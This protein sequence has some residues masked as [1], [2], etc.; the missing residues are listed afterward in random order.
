MNRAQRRQAARQ[1]HKSGTPDT[2]LRAASAAPDAGG[3]AGVADARR[4]METATRLYRSGDAVNAANIYQRVLATEPDNAD[5]LH[6]LGLCAG[7]MGQFD[8]AME[9]VDRSIALHPK[10]AVYHNNRGNRL[11]RRDRPEEAEEAY[12]RAVAIDPRDRRAW[13]NLGITLAGRQH[14]AK[15]ARAFHRAIKADKTFAEAHNNLANVLHIEGRFDAAEKSYRRAIAADPGYFMACNN[16]ANTLSAVGRC[17]EAIAACRRAVEIDPAYAVGYNTLASLLQGNG[18]FA[19]S[20]AAFRKSI[21][22]DPGS[23]GTWNNFGNALK[24]VGGHAE[25]IVCFGKA[26]EI[27]P[28]HAMAHSNLLFCMGMDAN[29]TARE[30]FIQSRRWNEIH[31]LPR[32]PAARR[33]ENDRDPERRLRVGYV[34]PDFR[35]HAVSHFIAPLIDAHDRDAVAVIAYA[36]VA[37]P[38]ETTHRIRARMDEWCDTVGMT[39][40]GLAARIRADRIDILVDLAGHTASNRLLTF[41]QRPAPVQVAWLGYGG[42]TGLDAMEYRLTD[43][44]ADPQGDADRVHS[45]TLV[46][47]AGGFLCY[48][49]PADAPEPGALPADSGGFVTFASFNSLA[50]VTPQAVSAWAR[51]LDAVPDAHLIIKGNALSD[52]GTRRRYLA[53]FA[54]EG[55]D[56]GRI[57]LAAQL[58]SRQEYLALY[59]RADIVLDSFPYNGGTTTCEALWMGVPVVTLAGDRHVSRMSASILGRVGADDLVAHSEDEYVATA[60]RLAGDRS[61][62]RELR[63]GLRATMAASPLCDGPAF[64]RAVE[65]A[66]RD[67][68]RRWCAG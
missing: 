25:A 5:A 14:Y 53:H 51:V 49:P 43:A 39:D 63:G 40:A 23:A 46:R 59:N 31:A 18:E 27:D 68:W 2:P 44:I 17:D 29:S 1:N 58:P 12:R 20:D 54:A 22:L 13:N 67:M 32:A 16:L 52:P 34:S 28:H 56:E 62:L 47:L 55:I 66:F 24:S 36:H 33:H 64:A 19:E 8:T 9:L 50:K 61:R 10:C 30:I 15:A 41:A 45:E 48:A 6:Y 4:D 38:D 26:L 42:T 21:A 3:A 37:A 57:E 35:N 7:D 65:A 60:A 11:R